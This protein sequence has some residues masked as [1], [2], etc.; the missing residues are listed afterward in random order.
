MLRRLIG[1]VCA[2]ISSSSIALAGQVWVVGPSEPLV[3]IHDAVTVAAD[4]DVILVRPGTYEPFAVV[5]KSLTIQGDPGATVLLFALPGF[6]LGDH[7]I[8]VYD[9]VPGQSLTVRG[10]DFDLIY[11]EPVAALYV[12]NCQGSVLFE[13][14]T[15]V[16]SHGPGA[17][18]GSS[19]SVTFEDCVIR[20]NGPF[21]PAA[22]T[23]WEVNPGLGVQGANVFLF[24]S[25][26]VG[27]TGY[28]AL[29]FFDVL[30]SDGG[31]GLSLH[32]GLVYATG[33]T[34]TGGEGG[35][36]S[37][38]WHGPCFALGDGGPGMAVDELFGASRV[39]LLETAVSGGLGGQP[40]PT[41]SDPPGADGPDRI[42]QAGTVQD[43]AGTGR[44]FDCASPAREGMTIDVAYAGLPGDSVY[45]VLSRGPG[46]GF[47][48]EPLLI[49]P[50]VDLG[51]FHISLRGVLPSSG[52]LAEVHRAP[53]LGTGVL[54]AQFTAQALYIDAQGNWFLSGP[55]QT[56][57]LDHSL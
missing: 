30:T 56:L 46:F 57:V 7:T 10:I 36:Y 21:E 26:I 4:G 29:G 20:S 5:G 8:Q 11:L 32:A 48:Y 17:Q 35:S 40:D 45:L 3:Q 52:V 1:S 50:H 37:E 47:L 6:G 44:S 16:A 49:A 33:C 27:S 39:I 54:S 23:S 18:V 55:S 13:D 2:L 22:S 42:V 53:Q 24:D 9:L 34:I 12:E 43:L 15:F 25:E 41:C 19:S 31:P 38:L 51:T 28:D 14:C